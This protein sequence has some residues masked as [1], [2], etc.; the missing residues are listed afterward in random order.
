MHSFDWYFISSAEQLFTFRKETGL[1][2][3]SDPHGRRVRTS[4]EQRHTPVSE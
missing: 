2:G 3:I 1:P 4:P